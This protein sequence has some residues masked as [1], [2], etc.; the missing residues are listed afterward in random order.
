MGFPFG[1]KKMFWN[2]IMV[3]DIPLWEYTKNHCT[4]H[5]KRRNFVA[6]KL[7]LNKKHNSISW[8]V[9]MFKRDNRACLVA[10]LFK[11]LATVITVLIPK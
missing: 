3:M 8:G 1:V 11:M 5:F 10:C 9:V 2:E 6:C 7:Y 4:V